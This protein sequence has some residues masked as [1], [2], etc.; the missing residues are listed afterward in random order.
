[1]P[2][3]EMAPKPTVVVTVSLTV[4]DVAVAVDGLAA[5]AI[6]P[7]PDFNENFSNLAIMCFP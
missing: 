7:T 2:L 5:A 4:T 3:A 1:M 6:E